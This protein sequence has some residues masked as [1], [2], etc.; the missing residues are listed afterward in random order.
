MARSDTRY[1]IYPAPKAVEVVG[2]TAP[3][4]NQ[5]VEC[6]AA[7]LARA[8]ADNSR[9]FEQA[10]RVEMNYERKMS[11]MNEWSLL[12]EA[13]KDMHSILNLPVQ[14]IYW[15]PPSR[16]PTGSNTSAPSA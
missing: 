9:T 4:L 15:P 5:A 1:S 3:A 16:T 7:L 2:D 6:W 10:N 8:T 14:A 11:Q 13:L 12:A